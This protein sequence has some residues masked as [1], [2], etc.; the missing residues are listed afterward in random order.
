MKT[1]NDI[2]TH[3]RDVL[4]TEGRA[5]LALAEQIDEAFLDAARTIYECSGKVVLTGVGK[6][7]IIGQKISATLASTGTLS[8]YLHPV[9]ALHGDLGRLQ[10]D[11][12]VIAL[13]NSGASREIVELLDHMKRRGATKGVASLCAGGGMG[14]A[15]VLERG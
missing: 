12:V 9:E 3:A 1:T 6:A 5:I 10:R 14:T 4:Q 15:L 11:D 2:I 7:G 13:S 8:I